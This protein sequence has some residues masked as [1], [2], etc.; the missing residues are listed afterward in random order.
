MKAS[1]THQGVLCWTDRQPILSIEGFQVIGPEISNRTPWIDQAWETRL[2]D[3]F[4]RWKNGARCDLI[5]DQLCPWNLY[6]PGV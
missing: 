2:R 5:Q 1:K 6:C 4:R 3:Q